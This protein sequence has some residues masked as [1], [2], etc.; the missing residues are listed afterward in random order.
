[1]SVPVVQR[2]YDEHG[3]VVEMA[4]MN[5]DRELINDPRSGVAVTRYNYNELGHPADTI[6]FNANMET[7]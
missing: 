5:I 4:V 3:S 7:L 1:M 2:T 6:R